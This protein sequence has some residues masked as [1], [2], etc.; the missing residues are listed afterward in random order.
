M[1]SP[2]HRPLLDAEYNRGLH[3]FCRTDPE[4]LSNQCSFAKEIMRSQHRDDGFLS[5]RRS[6]RDLYSAALNKKDGVGRITLGKDCVTFF[7]SQNALALGNM[8]Q[9]I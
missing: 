4:R 7:Q 1:K 5:R 6:H 9:Q 3:D 2:P 8:F